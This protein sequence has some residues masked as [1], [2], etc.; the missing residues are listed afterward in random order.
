MADTI[1]KETF[2]IVLTYEMSVN[3]DTGEILETR[4][5]DRNIGKSDLK[6]GRRL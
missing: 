6:Q 2:T 4:L 5:I 3:I 1:K